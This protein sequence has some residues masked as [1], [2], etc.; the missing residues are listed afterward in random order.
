MVSLLFIFY[1][2]VFFFAAQ[3]RT[4]GKSKE[5]AVREKKQ[6][7]EKRLQD[8]QGQL[9]SVKKTKSKTGEC[10]PSVYSAE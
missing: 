5:E 2:L 10:L 1:S 9:G 6:E 4:P 8:V 7:L 3:K